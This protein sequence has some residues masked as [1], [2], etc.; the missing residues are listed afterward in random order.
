MKSQIL[1]FA[2]IA[3][4]TA[5]GLSCKDNAKSDEVD[6]NVFQW[7]DSNQQEEFRPVN[8]G[9]KSSYFK[10]DDNIISFAVP[11]L[12]GTRV[13]EIPSEPGWGSPEGFSP[14]IWAIKLIMAEGTN[15]TSLS[16][17]IT[18]VSGATITRIEWIINNEVPPKPD[19]YATI[20]VDYTGIAKVDV[21]NF[22][23]QVG[24]TVLAPDG[25]TVNYMCSAIAIGDVLPNYP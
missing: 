8:P 2:L 22:K 17:I 12:V 4:L 5:G 3:L 11:N 9:E 1:K 13:T 19:F 15:V 21:I 25:S 18:L 10:I 7:D 24:F 16:P 14:H 23:Y 6:R 20:D